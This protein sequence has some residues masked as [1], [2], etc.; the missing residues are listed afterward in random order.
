MS[1]EMISIIGV[2]IAI[3]TGMGSFAG[4]VITLLLR[5]DRRIDHTNERIDHLADEVKAIALG[6]ARLEGE[7]LVLK[8]AILLRASGQE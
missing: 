8:D 5:L 4:L 1:P 6:Q 3:L 7:V 2:G